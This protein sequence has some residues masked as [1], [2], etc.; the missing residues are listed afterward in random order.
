MHV[1]TLDNTTL[2]QACLIHV[3]CTQRAHPIYHYKLSV[4]HT[5]SRGSCWGPPNK[6]HGHVATLIILI[7][8]I[9]KCEK[10]TTISFSRKRLLCKCAADLH[11][12]LGIYRLKN[13]IT[14][15]TLAT[16]KVMLH[17]VDKTSLGKLGN[18]IG[19]PRMWALCMCVCVCVHA[20]KRRV[21]VSQ[22]VT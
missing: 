9:W 16:S 6:F 20:R 13:L 4:T 7:N 19:I 18:W 17:P 1:I 12:H 5:Y 14:L 11:F 8:L 2:S 21:C 3:T 22:Q 15:T 10:I